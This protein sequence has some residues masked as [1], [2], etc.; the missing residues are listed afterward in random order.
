MEQSQYTKNLLK[1]CEDMGLRVQV[2]D[3]DGRIQPEGQEPMSEKDFAHWV[4]EQEKKR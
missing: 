3:I 2:R 4:W 1:K